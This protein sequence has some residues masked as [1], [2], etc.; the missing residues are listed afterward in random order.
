MSSNLLL[1]NCNP[2]FQNKIA[3]NESEQLL[4]REAKFKEIY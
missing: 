4:A 1:R 3:K 2:L